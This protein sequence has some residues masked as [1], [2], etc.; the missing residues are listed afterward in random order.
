M[1]SI[2][3][4]VDMLCDK[5]KRYEGVLFLPDIKRQLIGREKLQHILGTRVPNTD[6][7]YWK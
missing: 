3:I 1:F 5:V 7:C 6:F 4:Y 2:K